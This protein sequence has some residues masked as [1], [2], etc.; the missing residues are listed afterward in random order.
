MLHI[1][2]KLPYKNDELE[3]YISR[4]TMEF[5]Y[6]K[7]HMG[8]VSNV[9]NLVP[10]T[11]YEN[12]DIEAIIKTS[13]GGL[14]NNSAQA[15]NHTFYFMSLSPKPASE[16]AGDLAKEINKQ[17][18]SLQN[19]IYSFSHKAVTLFGSGWVWLV[20]KQDGSIR[21]IPE[22]NAGTPLLLNLRPL[23]VIDVWEHAYYLDYQNRRLDYIK[24]FWKILDWSV[25]TRRYNEV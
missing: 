7:H 18:G 1:L 23:L 14:F 17:F 16:P 12:S 24:N 5:H 22:P 15:W 4:K 6:G 21:I 13:D 10:G 11:Q 8:Y 25:V 20:K 9:N 2:P 3:P 19:F